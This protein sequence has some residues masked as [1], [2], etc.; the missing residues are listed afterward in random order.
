MSALSLFTF[1]AVA[2][3]V[4]F[5]GAIIVVAAVNGAICVVVCLLWLPHKIK[6]CTK[7]IHGDWLFFF[8][9]SFLFL[10]D[11]APSSFCHQNEKKKKAF[12]AKRQLILISQ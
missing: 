5:A 1:V 10:F 11:F 3:V 9:L 7:G 4:A 6:P 12:E 2:L 8:A